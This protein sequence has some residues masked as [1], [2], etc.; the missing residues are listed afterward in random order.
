MIY[1]SCEKLEFPAENLQV[2][3]VSTL[4]IFNI[5]EQQCSSLSLPQ[6][7]FNFFLS[8]RYSHGEIGFTM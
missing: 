5:H 4:S 3:R 7:L 1:R 8:I 6:N 2:L